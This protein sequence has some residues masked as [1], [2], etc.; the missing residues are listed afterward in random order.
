[1]MQEKDA[2]QIMREFNARQSRQLVAVAI[3]LFLV[4][5]CG[6]IYKRPDLFGAFSKGELFGAQIACIAA[7]IG[8]ASFNWRCPACRGHLGS[9]LFRRRCN[10]CGA[11]MR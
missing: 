6:V 4:L 1:M 11:R 9:D 2:K 3:T 10:K 7:F 8:Y 5:S